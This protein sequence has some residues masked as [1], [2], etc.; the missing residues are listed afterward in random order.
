MKVIIAGSR[1]ITDPALI[2]EAVRLSQFKI[3]E[4]V[5][6]AARGVDTL[7]EGWASVN[8]LP[9]KQFPANWNLYGKAAGHIRNNE[10]ASYA[11]ALI[12]IWDGESRGTKHM[13]YTAK[14]KGLLV[15]VHSAITGQPAFYPLPKGL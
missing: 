15:Y 12:A 2:K 14:N 7:G 4:V 13:I 5:S 9:V 11:D 3:T 6:G 10:M 8:R 1:G